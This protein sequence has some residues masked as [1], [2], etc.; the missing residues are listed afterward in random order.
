MSVDESTND[1]GPS[2]L[3]RTYERFREQIRT[4]NDHFNRRT[5]WMITMES[6][7]FAT[8]GLLMQSHLSN[9]SDHHPE[10]RFAFEIIIAVTG[11]VVG[12]VA[13]RILLHAVETI[14]ELESRWEKILHDRTTSESERIIFP[15]IKGRDDSKDSRLESFM[16]ADLLP[17]IFIVVWGLMAILFL[18]NFCKVI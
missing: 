14:E 8:V 2:L 7:L 15:L 16:K 13:Y 5:V 3:E 11:A 9:P 17:V 6:L 1:G 10:L 4:E 18:A 12:L